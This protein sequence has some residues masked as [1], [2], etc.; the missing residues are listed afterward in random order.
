MTDGKDGSG[1]NPGS[2]G[3]DP[4]NKTAKLSMDQAFAEI[5]KYKQMIPEK[6]AVIA[7]L[8]SQLEEANKVLEGQEK[9]RLIGEILPRSTFKMDELLGKSAEELKAIRVTLEA[10]MPPK[11]NSVRFGVMSADVSDK[12][13]GL[14]VGDISWCTAQKRKGAD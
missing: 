3:Q 8:T 9:A 1:S 10:A 12:D 5:E 2:E 7:D 14:T 13:L 11:V 6:D 4:K